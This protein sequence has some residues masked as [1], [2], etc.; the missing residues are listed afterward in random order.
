MVSL[1]VTAVSTAAWAQ[2]FDI[3][4]VVVKAPQ[5]SI[6]GQRVSGIGGALLLSG[7]F[8]VK[9]ATGSLKSDGSRLL[10]DGRPFS[11]ARMTPDDAIFSAEA[12]ARL[13][14]ISTPLV[15]TVLGQP[16]QLRAGGAPPV[17]YF[18]RESDG[19]YALKALPVTPDLSFEVTPV[20]TSGA[21]VVLALDFK[22]TTLGPRVP[23]EGVSLDVGAPRLQEISGRTEADTKLGEWLLIALGAG[24]GEQKA[25]SGLFLLLKTVRR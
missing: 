10:I 4:F 15:T 14:V 8:A 20:R 13:A 2:P 1:A 12:P 22:L 25:A 16:A 11:A 23:L 5:V 19:H 18:E 9:S 24:L 21:S 7:V 3:Q 6:E 17:Q